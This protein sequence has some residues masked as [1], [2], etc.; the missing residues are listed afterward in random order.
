MTWGCRSDAFGVRSVRKVEEF[1]SLHQ[2]ISMKFTRWASYINLNRDSM[3][4]VDCLYILQAL[5]CVLF[6][7]IPLIGEREML[8]VCLICSGIDVSGNFTP[9]KI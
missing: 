5:N 8:S 3:E 1:G 4:C 6:I 7:Y 2:N 9:V